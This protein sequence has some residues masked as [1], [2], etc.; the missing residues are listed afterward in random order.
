[1]DEA[2]GLQWDKTAVIA[3]TVGLCNVAGR[4]VAG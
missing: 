2:V 4:Q 1:M 3:S